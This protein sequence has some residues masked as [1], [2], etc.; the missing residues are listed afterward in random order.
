MRGDCSCRSGIERGKE[1]WAAGIRRTSH[2]PA[3]LYV[4][5]NVTYGQRMSS[6][7]YQER[8]VVFL[9]ILG[10]KEL[11]RQ[12]KVKTILQA[13]RIIQRRLR[14]LDEI[15]RCPIEHTMFS[16]SVVF[17]APLSDDGVVALVH[18]A[19]YLAAALFHKGVFCRG[20]ITTGKL[21]HKRATIFGP[22][23]IEAYNMESQLALYPRIITPFAIAEKFLHIK[24]EDTHRDLHRGMACYFRQDSDNQFHVDVLSPWMS[25]P[26]R[27]GL[28]SSTVVRPIEKLVLQQLIDGDSDSVAAQRA[29]A[30]LF[31][32]GDYLRY[33]SEV[34]GPMMFGTPPKRRRKHI[35]SD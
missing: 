19:A 14:N 15:P 27:Q 11:V 2:P 3:I 33:V 22:A 6:N 10:F 28:V 12:D 31:W 34:H 35:T 21:Y 24:N 29:R 5:V 9:D 23:L 4:S 20:A 1:T 32:L 26:P 17:S 8:V 16:D 30:K 13:M 18:N 25:R 7:S